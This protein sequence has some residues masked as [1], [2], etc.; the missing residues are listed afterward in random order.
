[1]NLPMILLLILAAGNVIVYFIEVRAGVVMTLALVVYL[2]ALLILRY[3]RQNAT[4]SELITFA[5]QYG[6]VQ[7]QLMLDFSMP[8]A[9]T[10]AD[11]R[12][13]WFNK[14]FAKL[15]GKDSRH[16][17]RSITGLFS[18]LT[19]DVIEEAEDGES[20]ETRFL[21]R[22]FEV[23]I[24]RIVLDELVDNSDILDRQTEDSISMFAFLFRDETL[25]R[26]YMQKYRDETLVC[27]LIYL[28]N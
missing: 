17:Q 7:K 26:E 21:D 14:S 25:L 22:V 28:D 12:L 4:M 18:N 27:S 13:L 23:Q 9:L 15:T 19:K 10:D 24:S 8:Y 3:R 6:Q 16:Y 1:M 2:I 20:V 5:A 11:G